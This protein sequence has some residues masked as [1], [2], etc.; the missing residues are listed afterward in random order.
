MFLQRSSFYKPSEDVKID[1]NTAKAIISY[2]ILNG[3]GRS[4]MPVQE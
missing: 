2:V 4:F 3:H 1:H